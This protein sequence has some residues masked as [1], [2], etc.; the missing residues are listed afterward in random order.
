MTSTKIK[1]V[2]VCAVVLAGLVATLLAVRYYHQIR[3]PDHLSKV[4]LAH[5]GNEGYK[6]PEAAL[7]TFLWAITQANYPA[8]MASATPEQRAKMENEMKDED[9]RHAFVVRM[10]RNAVPVTGYKIT[11]YNAISPD[12]IVIDVVTEGV[13][14]SDEWTFRKIGDEWKFSE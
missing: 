9:S 12:I 8:V 10:R 1:T 2:T 5:E 4:S 7:K 6:T 11:G 3:L 13:D 14:K